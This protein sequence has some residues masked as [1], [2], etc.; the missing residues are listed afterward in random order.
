MKAYDQSISN[1]VKEC[2]N[3]PKA[4]ECLQCYGTHRAEAADC[5][6]TLLA[7]TATGYRSHPRMQQLSP[8]PGKHSSINHVADQAIVECA[9]A[10]KRK[11]ARLCGSEEAGRHNLQAACVPHCWHALC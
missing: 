7:P 9:S 5:Q 4:F 1:T 6:H 8:V 3:Q 11:H 10:N 2:H